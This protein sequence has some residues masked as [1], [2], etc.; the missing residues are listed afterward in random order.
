[1]SS[2]MCDLDGVSFAR[3]KIRDVRFDGVHSR[4][5]LRLNCTDFSATDLEAVHFM[6]CQT[7]STKLECAEYRRIK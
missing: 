3:A 4:T 7:I 1:M 5:M 2:Y 6:R